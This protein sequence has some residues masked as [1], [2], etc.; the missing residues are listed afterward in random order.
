M[1][2]RYLSAQLHALDRLAT[3]VL[4]VPVLQ[5]ERPPQGIL[6]LVDYRLGGYLSELILQGTLTGTPLQQLV[7][8]GRPKLAFDKILLVGAG[9]AAQFQPQIYAGVLDGIFHTLTSWGVRRAAIELPGRRAGLIEIELA[10][11]ILFDR[12]QA[13]PQ[14]DVWTLL[15]HGDAIR[16]VQ[17]HL[18]RDRKQEWLRR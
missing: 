2:L 4:V 7:I 8:S 5:G 18:S 6:G 11:D 13:F 12:A 10:V 16:K 15:D 3:D 17:E 1:E 9:V 14:F